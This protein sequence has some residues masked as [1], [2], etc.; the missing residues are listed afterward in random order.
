MIRQLI[1]M[2]IIFAYL[3]Y[4]NIHLVRVGKLSMPRIRMENE[5][6]KFAKHNDMG[7][8]CTL[9]Q[10]SDWCVGYDLRR[11]QRKIVFSTFSCLQS[12]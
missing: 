11:K 5:Y 8:T 10:S 7:E 1:F 6:A 2:Y 9:R 12:G 3:Y 4:S